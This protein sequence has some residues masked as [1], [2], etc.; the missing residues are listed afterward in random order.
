[1]IP[2]TTI[3]NHIICIKHCEHY[4][5]PKRNERALT[6]VRIP[7]PPQDPPVCWL[8]ALWIQMT[9]VMCRFNLVQRLNC[10]DSAMQ[11][12]C[13]VACEVAWNYS[14]PKAI[15]VYPGLKEG[16]TTLQKYASRT[17]SYINTYS[18]YSQTWVKRSYLPSI[19]SS[20]GYVH[21]IY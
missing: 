12:V 11:V 16:F 20:S 17:F 19:R 6:Q 2:N 3:C 4:H 18:C 1:M 15:L 13:E 8:R 7:N 5:H 9:L 14:F 21:T 10:V